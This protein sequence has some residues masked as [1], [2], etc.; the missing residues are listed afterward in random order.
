MATPVTEVSETRREESL[1]IRLIPFIDRYGVLLVVLVMA[2]ASYLLEPEVFLTWRN[3]GNI[4]RQIGFNALLALGE[5]VVI[6]TA[7]IDL[8]VGSALALA[9]MTTAV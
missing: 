1:S 6:V 9:M 3:I 8:S 5:F 7:G 4:F 2:F